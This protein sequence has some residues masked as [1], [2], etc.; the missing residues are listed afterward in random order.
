MAETTST[1]QRGPPSR[2]GKSRGREK[3][4]EPEHSLSLKTTLGNGRL[5]ASTSPRG[6]S[7][8]TSRM[9]SLSKDF[10]LEF[11]Y[12]LDAIKVPEKLCFNDFLGKVPASHIDM[13]GWIISYSLLACIGSNCKESASHV[14]LSD[15]IGFTVKM[16]EKIRGFKKI[17]KL[18]LDNTGIDITFQAAQILGSLSKLMDLNISGC[19]VDITSFSII[20]N[21]CQQLRQLTCQACPGLDDYCLQALAACMQRFRRLHSVDLSRG[22]EYSDE[23]FLTVLG[24]TPKLLTR[25]NMANCTNIS[26]LSMTALRT[27]MPALIFLDI[28]NLKLLQSTFEWI[29]EGCTNVETLLM[30]NCVYLDDIA[31]IR[32][33]KKCLKLK[34]LDISRCEKV[35]DKG[36]I[37]FFEGLKNAAGLK[38]CG[39]GGLRSLDLS[40]N[41]DCGGPTVEALASYENVIQSVYG[42][43]IE[44]LK[45]N[46]LSMVTAEALMAMWKT[47]TS[48]KRFEMAVELK[49]AV[50][51]R[52]SMMPH[53]SDEILIEAQ[54]Q[55]RK[56][57]V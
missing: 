4:A 25:L 30:T 23:G 50:T 5:S 8:D 10:A 44:E 55:D 53:I 12:D 13:S 7:R 39:D 46:G 19:K 14:I 57:V 40:S 45:M 43:G 36:M 20:C 2:S 52:K 49:Q 34:K 6:A 26:T 15:A 41:I 29:S 51:H 38:L 11:A 42:K 37:G 1:S 24:A 3:R 32:F 16:M 54:Y 35:T 47:C 18:H 17:R 31:M 9:P 22:I 28:S 21:T 27:S 33:G 56:S 48:I